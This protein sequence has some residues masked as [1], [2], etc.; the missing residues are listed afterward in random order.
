V[1]YK[2]GLKMGEHF[3][4]RT[5]VDAVAGS[6]VKVCF[7]ILRKGNGKLCC[8]GWFEYNLINLKSGRLQ[9]I[10]DHVLQKYCV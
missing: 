10:P 5:W 3:I 2:R 6:E 8:N 4:V 1:E 7:E 9:P